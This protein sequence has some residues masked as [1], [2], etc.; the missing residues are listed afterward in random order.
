VSIFRR[1][2]IA[3]RYVSG[4]IDTDPPPGEAKSIGADA[5]HAWCSIWIPDAGWLDFD[6]TNDQLP[7][8]R[9]IT[10]AWGLDYGDVAPVRGVV[11]GPSA[12]QSLDVGV[13]VELL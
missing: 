4:Y 1:R 7:P 12:A 9:H 10:V 2:G 3:A 5:S 13:H 11:I 6:P 8:R